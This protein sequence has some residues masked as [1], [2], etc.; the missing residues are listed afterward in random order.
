MAWHA[1]FTELFDSATHADDHRTLAA[2]VLVACFL[3]F[4]LAH[5]CGAAGN[6]FALTYSK[7]SWNYPTRSF[8]GLRSFSMQSAEGQVRETSGM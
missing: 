3:E 5:P 7:F 4:R 6:P 1:S 2:E 8:D